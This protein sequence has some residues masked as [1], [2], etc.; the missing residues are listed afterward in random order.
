MTEF[1]VSALNE[2]LKFLEL[3]QIDDTIFKGAT[4][5]ETR[6]RVFGGLVAAQSLLSAGKTVDPSRSVHSLHGYFLVG[7]HPGEPITYVVEKVRDGGSFTTRRVVAQQHGTPIFVMTSSFQKHE[8]G[9]EHST[10]MPE[11]IS[12]PED[13]PTWQERL[14]PIVDSIDEQTAKWLV[15]DRPIDTRSEVAP[16]WVDTTSRKPEQDVWFKADGKLGDDPLLHACIIAYAS[17]LTLLDTAMLPYGESLKK[18]KFMMASLDHAMWFHEPCRADEWLLYHQHSPH[19]SNS[20]AL[21]YGEIFK[22]DGTHVLTV[23]Q[24]GLVRAFKD[25]K[26]AGL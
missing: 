1:N 21:A 11:N 16:A 24:E 6:Q 7:G 18:S 22:R 20:R 8:V 12:N 14:A 4:P 15:K 26:N 13:L 10:S 2:L 25:R 5:L 17:D 19:A 3:D 9:F 23:V